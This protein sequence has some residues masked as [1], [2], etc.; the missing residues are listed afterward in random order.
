MPSFAQ[1][2]P[3]TRAAVA[4]AARMHA[5]QCRSDGTPFILHPIEV[6]SL[7]AGV[8]APDHVVAAGMLHDVIEKADVTASDLAERFGPRITG[9][10][11]TVSDDDQIRRYAQR[12]AALRRQLQDAGR[13][14]LTLFA[15]DKVSKV[16]ELQ[17]E[18]LAGFPSVRGGATVGA[19]R[20]GRLHHYRMCLALLETHL[21]DS[22]LVHELRGELVGLRSHSEPAPSAFAGAR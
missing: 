20:A 19:T 4:F 14:A 16:R 13:E 7:L 17:R 12:K 8:D 11:V 6:A 5:G 21:G 15:A 9:L 22:P 1:S 3:Q 2:R 18:T 10:V